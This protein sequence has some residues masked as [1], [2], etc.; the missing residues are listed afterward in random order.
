MRLCCPDN[1]VAIPLVKGLCQ[2]MITGTVPEA[3]I[4]GLAPSAPSQDVLPSQ[5][6]LPASNMGATCVHRVICFHNVLHLA[7]FPETGG[8]SNPFRYTL[9]EK[10]C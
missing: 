8:E 7:C 2:M 5:V 4:C 9:H 3:Q 1:S 6:A 10:I